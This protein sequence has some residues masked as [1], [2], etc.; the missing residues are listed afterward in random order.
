MSEIIEVTEAITLAYE[1]LNPKYP[2]LQYVART[3]K[4]NKKISNIFNS[5]KR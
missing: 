1:Y 5:T 3:V 4:F 2:E